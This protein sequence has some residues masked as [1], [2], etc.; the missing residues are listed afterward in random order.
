MTDTLRY[1]ELKN[2]SSAAIHLLKAHCLNYTLAY[3]K[4]PDYK[5]LDHI[6]EMLNAMT[7]LS[8]E[9]D[10]IESTHKW[11]KIYTD[12]LLKHYGDGL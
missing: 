2:A 4:K 6:R 11:H 3:A 8:N 5:S 9:M 12:R 10:R 7:M 1:E